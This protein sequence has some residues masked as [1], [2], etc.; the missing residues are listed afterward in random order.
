[1]YGLGAGPVLLIIL[2]FEIYGFREPNEDRALLKQRAERGR[3]ANTELGIGKKP[4]WWNKVLGDYYLT[5]EERLKALSTEVGGGSASARN[6]ERNIELDEIPL[7][8][9]RGEHENPFRDEAAVSLDGSDERS[10][11]ATRPGTAAP[12]S[13]QSQLIR[14]MLDV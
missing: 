1:M 13:R 6:V 12:P 8:P 2:V 3:A 5:N 4:S 10:E 9:P 7:V 14:S 11:G